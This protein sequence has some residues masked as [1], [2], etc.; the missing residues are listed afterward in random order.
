VLFLRIVSVNTAACERG[1]AGMCAS[2][3]VSRA[4]LTTC[5]GCMQRVCNC[6]S[7]A[8]GWTNSVY[9]TLQP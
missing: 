1:V 6:L 9:G 7:L 5:S 3:E 8:S 4:L 2:A